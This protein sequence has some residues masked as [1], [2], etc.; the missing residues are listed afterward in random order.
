[1]GFDPNDFFVL[2]PLRW[3]FG[4]TFG[5]KAKTYFD[6]DLA[7]VITAFVEK[8]GIVSLVVEELMAELTKNGTLTHLVNQLMK[9]L[10]VPAKYR[11]VVVEFIESQ[12]KT[13]IAATASKKAH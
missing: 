6:H 11:P 13:L 3:A 4:Q 9:D 2:R 12:A 8:K 10:G 7:P 5:S 1:M